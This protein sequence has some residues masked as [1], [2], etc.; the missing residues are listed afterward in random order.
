[1]CMAHA[2]NQFVGL[3]LDRFD[4]IGR[5]NVQAGYAGSLDDVT[6]SSRSNQ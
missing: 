1:M 4:Q 5:D 6:G 2:R 3:L